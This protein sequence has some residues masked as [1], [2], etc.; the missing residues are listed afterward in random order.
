MNIAVWEAD[1]TNLMRDMSQ[2]MQGMVDHGLMETPLYQAMDGHRRAISAADAGEPVE[3]LR[4]GAESYMQQA[5]EAVYQSQRQQSMV[6]PE[7]GSALIECN[8]GGPCCINT[9]TLGCSHGTG[10]LTLPVEGEQ[11]AKLTL[12]CDKSSS[13]MDTLTVDTTRITPPCPCGMPSQRPDILLKRQGRSQ[14]FSSDAFSHDITYESRG[15]TDGSDLLKFARATKMALY[16]NLDD[17]GQSH[18]LE[19]RNCVFTTMFDAEIIAF[20]KLS[21]EAKNFGYRFSGKLGANGFRAKYLFGGTLEGKYGSSAFEIKGGVDAAPSKEDLESSGQDDSAGE[22]EESSGGFVEA[23]KNLVVRT[24]AND[25]PPSANQT[26]IEISHA[27]DLANSKFE[28]KEHPTDP[29]K[30]GV[31][32]SVEMA[33]DPLFG[34]EITIDLLELIIRMAPAGLS[35]AAL[36]LRDRLAKGFG[37]STSQAAG[38]VSIGLNLVGKAEIGGGVT[39]TRAVAATE[40]QGTGEAVGSVGLS[41]EG[42]IQGELRYYFVTGSMSA[43][44]TGSTSIDASIKTLSGGEEKLHTKVE[45]KGIRFTYRV[46]GT[47]EIGD[48]VDMSGGSGSNEPVLLVGGSI[49]YE[50]RS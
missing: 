16:S 3:A 31:E 24:K 11:E 35:T 32:A 44:G 7:N 20:P 49:L 34:V 2:S 14:T 41:I 22:A 36:E 6:D 47:L 17:V 19:Y 42:A 8:P 10:R 21:W 1:K 39:L 48:H 23:I 12:I 25:G 28:L 9:V 38:N 46:Q 15:G 30:V 43:S 26:S 37:S 33:F 50:K 27:V 45:W 18:R 29:A 13:P 4:S 40:W 5:D